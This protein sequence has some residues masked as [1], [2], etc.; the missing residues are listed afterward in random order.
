M[1]ADG[2]IPYGYLRDTIEFALDMARGFRTLDPEFELPAKVAAYLGADELADYAGAVIRSAI[3]ES[4]SF[5]TTLA[6]VLAMVPPDDAPIGAVGRLWL[7]RPDGW[8]QQAA[9]LVAAGPPPVPSGAKASRANKAAKAELGSLRKELDD[10]RVRRRKAEERVARLETRLEGLEANEKAREVE[11]DRTSARIV[12]LE[13][14]LAETRESA[15]RE[16]GQER[17]RR[18]RVEQELAAALAGRAMVEAELTALA[19][20]PTTDVPAPGRPRPDRAP[21][22]TAIPLRG[23]TEHSPEGVRELLEYPDVLVV[24]DGSNVALAQWQDQ[25]FVE[26][27]RRLLQLLKVSLP[28]SAR[29]VVWFDGEGESRTLSTDGRIV[30]GFTT[31]GEIADDVIVAEC[32]AR[33]PETRIVAATNDKE[34]AAR[35]RAIQVRVVPSEGL[36]RYLTG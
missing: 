13:T 29:A 6:A 17:V 8:E 15:A 19:S 1:G 12:T 22:R 25:E 16:L 7:E 36:V 24:V 14:E 23:H 32:Q 2:S 35:L 33:P 9:T 3:E 21:M 5:R 10:E 27:R 11:H 28:A 18:E 20:R 30:V 31:S 26:R 4:E 34:L